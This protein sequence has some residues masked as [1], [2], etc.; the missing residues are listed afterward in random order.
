LQFRAQLF[1]NGVKQSWPITLKSPQ[2]ISESPPTLVR[3]LRLTCN[4]TQRGDGGHMKARL[5]RPR[6]LTHA[7][8]LVAVSCVALSRPTLKAQV[9][10][11][12]ATATA[13]A[14]D[15]VSIKPSKPGKYGY[16]INSDAQNF[17]ASNI[18][19][20]AL[21]LSA[22]SLKE[23]QI[24]NL[25]KWSEGTRFDIKAKIIQPNIKA[26][27]ALTTHQYNAMQQPILTD[28]FHLQFHYELKTQPVYEL[29][30]VKNG[31]KFKETT[32]AELASHDGVNG[33]TAG[34][35]SIHN[36]SLVG[37]GI[38]MAALADSLSGQVHRIVVDK[39]GL[40]GKYNVT[41]SWAS[42]DGAPQ[43]PDSTL[44]VIF[45]AVQ[46]QLGLKLESGKAEVQGF[47]I[48]HA[49]IPSED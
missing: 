48:D 24:F 16:D 13:P 9:V 17:S 39:T 46:E 10:A 11:A 5:L 49:E 38:T 7:V 37:T 1:A 33:V 21:I 12:P 34:G 18:S 40:T 30:V 41:L 29:V 31:A 42:D 43:A 45:T 14:Y 35:I 26:I 15:I 25:P 27:D 3:T 23:S 28:R 8:F 2:I 36:R 22:Y 44:P 19:L 32:A 6:N 4:D 47:I 20:K